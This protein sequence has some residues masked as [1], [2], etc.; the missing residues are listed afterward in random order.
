MKLKKAKSIFLLPFLVLLQSS[1]NFPAAQEIQSDQFGIVY[2][3]LSDN[4]VEGLEADWGFAVWIDWQGEIVLFDTG[5]RAEILKNNLERL[6]LDP[7]KIGLVVIS[8][9]HND[10]SGGLESIIKELKQGCEVYLPEPVPEITKNNDNQKFILNDDYKK[11]AD[12]IWLSEVFM[13]R[14]NGIREMAIILER[15]A[16]LLLITGCAH[17]G[18]LKIAQ[19][20]SHHFPGRRIGLVTGGFHLTGKTKKEVEYISSELKNLGIIKIAPTHCTGGE[21]IKIFSNSWGDNFLDLNLG[22]IYPEN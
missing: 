15:E 10:H 2:D 16:D 21:A 17:P 20:V 12:G 9:A 5:T 14:D 8:H 11:I 7:G 1:G 13:D 18:I 6:G 4:K 19:G 22:A 3:N